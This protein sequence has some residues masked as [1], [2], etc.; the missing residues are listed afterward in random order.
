MEYTRY[1]LLWLF[2]FYSLAGW[3]IEVCAAAVKRRRF[4][5]V[6][7][8][9]GP[10]CPIYGVSAVAFSVLLTEL[11]SSFF[12]L[13]LGGM[14]VASFNEYVIGY[15][16]ERIFHRKWWDYS[17]R[18]FQVNGYICLE[19]ALLWGLGAILILNVFNP[20]LLKV[21]P[22]IPAFI[23]KILLWVF[24]A[25]FFLDAAGSSAAVFQM[26]RRLSRMALSVSADMRRLSNSLGG[27]IT[28]RIE[29][30]MERAY[31]GLSVEEI[32]KRQREM[33]EKT[34][35]GVFAEGCC[36]YKLACLFFIG[37]LL[38][39]LVE[40][41]FCYV[42]AGVLMS[43]SSL[44]YGPFSIVWGF[45][46]VFLTAFLYQYRERS[47]RVIF[48]AGTVLGGAYEYICSVLTELVF[49]T[50]FWDYSKI[51]FNLGGR[52]NLLYCFFWGIVA[53]VWL[54]MIYPVLSG[55]I[56]RLPKK[57]GEIGCKILLVLMVFDMGISALALARYSERQ[58]NETSLA[59]GKEDGGRD[60][61]GLAAFLDRHFPDE[62]MER[63][64]PNVIIVKK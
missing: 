44:V 25:V 33:R 39:D 40:T 50:V 64:Y 49:G 60:E 11:R 4:V 38:G 52:I 28:G 27:A 13:F 41:V 18:R 17:G 55:W 8:L 10:V 42:T 24:F 37:S 15:I 2:V 21:L 29:R 31:P 34:A 43:R 58:I 61:D 53:V 54:K 7:Y 48:L 51:P 56:E 3:G 1:Q 23:G 62:R 5:N 20:M 32:L 57:S 9:N 59:A 30:R 35:S 36:F 6:G 45:G 26:H 63:I 14:V 47:D 46:C 16:L 22:L 19:N 12:F